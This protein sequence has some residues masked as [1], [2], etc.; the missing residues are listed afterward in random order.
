MN[1]PVTIYQYR[2]AA[3]PPVGGALVCVAARDAVDAALGTGQLEALFRGVAFYTMRKLP[4]TTSA[5]G[6]RATPPACAACCARRARR[7][8]STCRRQ[9]G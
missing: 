5:Y 8:S 2:D 9:P 6:A 3:F 7:W 1:P 4:G